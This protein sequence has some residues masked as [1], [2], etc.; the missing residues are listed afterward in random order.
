[1]S[2]KRVLIS[3]LVVALI[4]WIAWIAWVSLSLWQA[5]DS[6]PELPPFDVPGVR[7]PAVA[8]PA[9]AGPAELVRPPSDSGPSAAATADAPAAI[10]VNKEAS[11]PRAVIASNAYYFFFGTNPT[12]EV[13]CREWESRGDFIPETQVHPDV[14]RSLSDEEF[15]QLVDSRPGDGLLQRIYATSLRA[16]VSE[17]SLHNVWPSLDDDE[18][19]REYDIRA[20][21]ARDR[22]SAAALASMYYEVDRVESNAWWR[23]LLEMGYDG[24]GLAIWIGLRGQPPYTEQES[25][26]GADRADEL[27]NELELL[28]GLGAPEECPA[29]D[30]LAE[31]RSHLATL[32]RRLAERAMPSAAPG[33]PPHA[34]NRLNGHALV[35]ENVC[36]FNCPTDVQRVIY[37]QDVPDAD[38]C[39]QIDGVQETI[40]ARTPVGRYEER[41]F[42]VPAFMVDN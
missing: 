28:S 4:A 29:P 37:Y 26:D 17:G 22:Q 30:E 19:T 27:I 9:T 36:S 34:F 16:T 2:T 15:Q 20:V 1:V 32:V 3:G 5:G 21:R 18:T 35:V 14:L 42:C 12:L 24:G 25:R 10:A 7:A 41:K 23:I 31:Q 6:L 39:G 38:A 40:Q 33:E 13:R 8:D 11:T